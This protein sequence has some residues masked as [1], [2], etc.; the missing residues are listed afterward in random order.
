MLTMILQMAGATALY[1]AATVLIWHFWHQKEKHALAQKVAVGLFYGLCS[2][3]SNHAG[4]NFGNMVLNVRDIGPLAAGLFFGPLAG[5]LAGLIGGI[6]RFIIGQYFGIGEFTRVACSLS[7]CLAGFLSAG[8]YQLSYRGKR[9]SVIHCLLIGA[10]MEVFHMYAVFLTNRS[11]MDMATSVVRVCALPMITFTGLGLAA[12]SLIIASGN[13]FSWKAYLARPKKNTPMDVRFQRWLLFVVVA[14]FGT[15][16]AVS[17]SL[18]TSSAMEAAAYRL[19]SDMFLYGTPLSEDVDVSL[20]KTKLD[21]A[22]VYSDS[23]FLLVDADRGLRYTCLGDG[24]ESVPADPGDL[25]LIAAHSDSISFTARLSLWPEQDFLCVADHVSGPYYLLIGIPTERIFAERWS[26]MLE[27]LFLEILIF[28]AFYLLVGVLVNRM[29]IRNLDR[30]NASL[31]R[32]TDGH[33]TE[34][35]SV[36]ESAEF[37]Q[38]SDDINT[39]VT[40]L[41]GFIDAA[42]KRMEEDLRLAAEIQDAAL[43]KDFRLPSENVELYALMDPARMVGGDFY[44]FFPIGPEHVA[45][46]IADVSGKGIPA[47]LFMMRAKTAIKSSAMGTLSPAKLLGDVN[48]TLCE[49][50]E[51]KMFV[52]VWLG[53]LDLKTGLMRCANAGHEFPAVMRA[54]GCYELLRDRHSLVLAAYPNIPTHEYEIQLEPGDR[55]LVYTDG[56]PDA[57][58]E[59]QEAYGTDRMMECLNS[60]KD[61]SQ[62]EILTRIRVDIRRFAGEAEQFDDITMLGIT[63]CRPD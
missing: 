34:V 55:L 43:P 17:Y 61:K 44:D 50:N 11:D 7:T 29:V 31:A 1:V 13:G 4:I 9:P 60:L 20:L 40:A 3:I 56:V 63:Y 48:N 53:I 24:S 2:V 14:L 42:E 26:D 62:V 30:V 21:Y 28:T 8:L 36:E 23:V 19:R 10:E 27:A 35:V 52:T 39:T 57:I 54:G 18:Q 37:T 59:K 45:L 16:T 6:E 15:S 51:A 58:N 5:I 38:L 41:R 22:S 32:I 12:C 46:V 47:S 25:A 49:G 33:L